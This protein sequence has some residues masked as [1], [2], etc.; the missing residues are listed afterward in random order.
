MEGLTRRSSSGRLNRLLSFY[1]VRVGANRV[2]NDGNKCP[3]TKRICLDLLTLTIARF[4]V[5]GED[6]TVSGKSGN[7]DEPT[8]VKRSSTQ[9]TSQKLNVLFGAP[10]MLRALCDPCILCICALDLSRFDPSLESHLIVLSSTRSLWN[11]H[12]EIHHFK[13]AR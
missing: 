2:T 10:S 11:I 3:M 8:Q 9:P 1:V 6:I 5:W 7:F 12:V 13:H 4:P